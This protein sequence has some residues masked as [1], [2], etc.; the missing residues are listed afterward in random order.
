MLLYMPS[1]P[2]QYINI[3]APVL[4]TCTRAF[5]FLSHQLC[6]LSTP[7]LTKKKERVQTSAGK[8]FFFM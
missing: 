2:H 4:H 5:F 7:V 6:E 3:K 1:P 8:V